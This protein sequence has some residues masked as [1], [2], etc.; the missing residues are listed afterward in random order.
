MKLFKKPSEEKQSTPKT[1]S[2]NSNETGLGTFGGVYTPSILTILGVIMYLRFG[3]VVGNV[4]LLGTLIIV[5]LSTGITFLTSLSVS[6]IATDRIVKGGG[7]YYMISRSLGIETGGAVGIPL[8]FAQALSVALYTIGFAESLVDAF[9]GLNQLYVALATT[10]AVAVLAISSAEIAI[11]AQYFIMAAIILSLVSF[12]FGHPLEATNIEMWGGSEIVSEPFWTVFAVFFPAVTGIM[13]GVSMS[14]DLREPSRSI[15]V[16]TLA[17]VGTGYLVYMVLPIILAMRADATTLIEQPLVMKEMAIWGPAIL[18]G[19]WG[20][21][22]SSAIGSILGAPRVLQA[23]AR[24]GV[25]PSWL[26]FLGH[27]SGQNDEPRIG[28]AITLGVATATVCIGDLN[29]IAP[30][31]TMFF[32]TTY[33]VL[34]VSAGIEGFLQSPS[35][36]PTFQVHWSLSMLG[37]LGCLAVMFLINAVATVIAAMIVLTIFI[38]LQRR[39]LETTWGDAR[40]GIWMALVREGILQL[41]EED[42]K[43]WRPHIL[44]LSGIAK[45]RWLLIQFADDLTHNRGMIT[46]CS[47]L[48]SASRDVSQQS[49]M[50]DTIREYLDK[51][52]VQALVRVVTATDFFDG[53]KLLVE[54]YGIGPLT[55]NTVVLGD[56]Q[57]PSR[58]DRYCQLIGHIHKAKKNVVIFREDSERGFGEYR[59]IDVWWGGLQNNGGLMLLLAYLLRTDIEWRNVEIYLKLV[60]PEQAAVQ[61]TQANV[62][63]VIRNLRIRVVSRILV[64][65]GRP[66]YDILHESSENADLIFLG[67]RTPGKNFTE[68]YQDLQSKTANLPSTVFVLAAPGFSY[69]EVLSD[70]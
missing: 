58:R 46:I 41:G 44:V 20:A 12:A 3:W 42:T 28:T 45:K 61:A 59:R 66:F 10:I 64:S 17:A 53:A 1:A 48:P 8:Y 67:I 7:A 62:D 69:G 29:I 38:W 24:D 34:N 32:L 27:G 49:D 70:R 6:A 43:N 56:S 18:L 21:T 47:V 5:T 22:L 16:G 15:P 50:Q 14:G 11:K 60:V 23:L 54:T 37:A 13:A 2:D 65:N 31:L 68:Y 36:R 63:R 55:P 51:R 30:V 26:S 33:M 57:E 39:E 4:G 35:F 9:G 25:L 40:R 19:V 52:G